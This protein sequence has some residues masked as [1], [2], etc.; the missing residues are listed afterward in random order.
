MKKILSV[1]LILALALALCLS[2]AACDKGPVVDTKIVG[3]D[4]SKILQDYEQYPNAAND[5]KMSEVERNVSDILADSS[6]TDAQK[7]AQAMDRATQNEIECAYFAFFRNQSGE[8]KIKKKS[9]QLIYQRLRKQSDDV[10]DDTTIKLPVN[11]NFGST[12]KNFV[13]S[14]DIRYVNNGK[15]NRI[16]KNS[17]ITYNE[18]TGLLEVEK[19][20]KHEKW[21][22]DEEAIWS[23]SYDEARKTC[24]NWSKENIIDDKN[25][26]IETK[27]DGN[28]NTYYE[29]TFSVNVAVANADKITIDRLTEDNSGKNMRFDYCNVI[30]QI[31]QNGLAKKYIIDEKWTGEIGAF[32]IWYNGSAQSKS[33]IIFSY[34]ERDLDFSA[35]DA[36][37]QNLAKKRK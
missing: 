11:H 9:G 12:E 30:A 16:T 28:G 33:E 14:A 37:Y 18:T 35:T 10:K 27:T 26:S 17:P 22:E 29:L 8:T 25:V 23:R 24:V 36:I 15:Y 3:V 21:N 13:T 20:K 1:T 34:S 7:V 32:V 6:L 31:W 2:I 4:Y 19:W 5:A